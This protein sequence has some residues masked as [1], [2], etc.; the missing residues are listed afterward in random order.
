MMRPHPERE[1]KPRHRGHSSIWKK[2]Y[3]KG[4]SSGRWDSDYGR[5]DKKRPISKITAKEIGMTII[6]FQITSLG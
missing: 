3:A 4:Q 5:W 2:L 1:K 6:Q